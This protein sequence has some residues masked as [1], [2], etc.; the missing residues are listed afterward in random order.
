[1]D[2]R[3]HRLRDEHRRVVDDVVLQ[4]V[5]K[6]LR[7][8]GHR[9]LHQG[10]G[11]E[12]VRAGP[13]EDA[14]R[15]GHPLVEIAAAVVVGGA[16]LDAANVAH[17]GDAA[18][19]VR[20]DD[21][22]AELIRT[23]E[24]PLRLDIELEG[25]GLGHGRL[26]DDAGGNLNVLGAQ[27]I[28][29]VA[30]GQVTY[31]KLLGIEPDAHRIVARAEDGH[32]ANT[33]DTSEHVLHV[34][35]RVVGDVQQVARA[36]RRGK[37]DHHHQVRR[38]LRHRHA[39]RAHLLGQA[40]QSGRNAILHQHLRGIEIGAEL[41]RDCQRHAAVA[42]RLRRHIEHVV[43]A[44]DLLLE[45]GCHGLG[46]DLG[47]GAGIARG[48][49]DRGR[50]D[51]GILGHRQAE[52]GHRPDQRD[53]DGDNGGEDRPVDEEMRDVHL[54]PGIGA[55]AAPWIL[56]C[57]G[58]TF[59]PGRARSS[60][61]MITEIVGGDAAPDYAKIVVGDGAEIDRFRHHGAVRRDDEQEL[62]RLIGHHSGVGHQHGRPVLRHRHA[63]AAELAGRDEQ[64]R[65]G[66]RGA[67]ADR[68]RRPIILVVDEIDGAFQRPVL[69][70]HELALHL[71][72]VAARRL[73][74]A[75]LHQALVG[76]AVAFADI[77]GEPDWIER[78]DGRK[79]RGGPGDAS[80]D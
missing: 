2:H 17:A 18:F 13:L 3:V 28:D 42:G 46:H 44:V 49:R 26:I 5:W 47:R 55:K 27:G 1:M 4:S 69:L 65:I 68:A 16:E 24:A 29:H 19:A 62:H 73:D 31:R 11:G 57:S 32:V 40:R 50:G 6:G 71:D 80:Y 15:D 66:E 75:F 10:S 48:D 74:L 53:D 20:L 52:I 78:D 34:Q 23:C 41:E 76:H 9:L 8:V 61:L 12:C 36:V 58:V 33:I 67:H 56:P 21:Y 45:R 22:V 30:R 63:Y 60:P 64:I 25:S 35:R 70:V 54:A 59:W 51:V 37:V 38:L 39:D 14:H 7:Q 72:G 77:E 79:H 43:D